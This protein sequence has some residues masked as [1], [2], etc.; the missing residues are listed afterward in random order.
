MP[1]YRDYN[2]LTCKI[3]IT[4]KDSGETIELREVHEVKV[5]KSYDTITDTCE[6][7]LP[8]DNRWIAKDG[9][10]FNEVKAVGTYKDQLKGRQG[11]EEKVIMQAG[12]S[13]EVWVGYDFNDKLVFE[14][15]ITGITPQSPFVL[16]CED[17]AWLLKRNKINYSPKGKVKLSEIADRILENTHVELHPQTLSEEIEFGK[18]YIRNLTAAQFLNDL[19]NEYGLISFI[20]EKKLVIGRTFFASGANTFKTTESPDYEPPVINLHY[21]VP[22]GGDGLQLNSLSSQYLAIEAISFLI[23]NKAIKITVALHPGDVSKLV[24]LDEEDP[25]WTQNQRERRKQEI[26]REVTGLGLNIR[27]Y[28][29]RTLHHYNLTRDQLLK[30][31][32]SFYSKY[33]GTGM[34]GNLTLFG[35]FN[36]E[37][38]TTVILLDRLNPEKN[39]EFIIQDVNIAFGQGGLRYHIH[40][41]HKIRDTKQAA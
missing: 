36:L 12:D 21:D 16:K 22:R 28:Q 41:P 17:T 30:S 14:G 5:E 37:P 24:I 25:N 6:I 15:F 32:Q 23:N 9:N 29:T 40:I 18:L 4:G 38:A 13:V 39:G 35:D 11:D 19:K 27:N 20:K 1:S 31:A 8:R 34:E 7:T 10:G 26:E 33:V 2:K 3:I